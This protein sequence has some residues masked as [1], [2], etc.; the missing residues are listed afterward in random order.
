MSLKDKLFGKGNAFNTRLL[1]KKE[2]KGAPAKPKAAKKSAVVTKSPKKSGG[3]KLPNKAP[4]PASRPVSDFKSLSISAGGVNAPAKK[5]ILP[6][7]KPS[8]KKKTSGYGDDPRE[9]RMS[10]AY[11]ANRG[12]KMPM[13][14]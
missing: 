12:A 6:G 8:T 4:V 10:K 3:M 2:A 7:A 14:K 1:K 11:M 9:T 5:K 13:P